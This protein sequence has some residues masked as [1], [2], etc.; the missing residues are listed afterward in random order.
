[1]GFLRYGRRAHAL[2]GSLH[3][4]AIGD[5]IIVSLSRHYDHIDDLHFGGFLIFATPTQAIGA[6][7]GEDYVRLYLGAGTMTVAM[8]EDD[9]FDQLYTER[10]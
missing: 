1:M 6:R 3:E 10:R 8:A 9:E 4:V 7:K 2:G 5:R